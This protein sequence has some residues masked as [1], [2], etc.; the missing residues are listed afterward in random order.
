MAPPKLAPILRAQLAL[1]ESGRRLP[2]EV[3]AAF[4]AMVTAI[5]ATIAYLEEQPLDTT[6][7]DA[8]AGAERTRASVLAMRQ[9]YYPGF[10]RL[11]RYVTPK[12]MAM[13]EVAR[14]VYNG[15]TSKTPL[16]YAVNA[17]PDYADIAQGTELLVLPAE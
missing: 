9:R 7:H 15:D 16:L 6:V 2:S 14:D 12:R 8:L 5:D 17:V 4:H 11:R 1:I 13:W 10:E 3:D